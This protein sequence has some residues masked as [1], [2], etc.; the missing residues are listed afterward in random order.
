MSARV[1]LTDVARVTGLAVSTVSMALR[2]DAT[3]ALETQRR[4]QKTADTLGYRPN[5]LLSALASRHFGA[6]QGRDVPIAY[7]PLP[8]MGLT[9]EDEKREIAA[10]KEHSRR[11]GY[12]LE[13]FHPENFQD[14]VEATRIL[15]ARGIQG[16]LLQRSFE[17][18][19]LPG[20]DWSRFSLVGL[21]ERMA[22][23]HSQPPLTTAY[24]A[25]DHF[26]QVVRVWDEIWKRGYRRIGIALFRLSDISLDDQSRWGATQCCLKR[27]PRQSRIP[28]H[29]S[30]GLQGGEESVQQF[31]KWL[32]RYQPDA[33]LGFNG[34]F[35]ALLR[36]Q[37][38]RSPDD[39]GF[40]GLY[41]NLLAEPGHP[42]EISIAGMEEMRSHAILVAL[43]LLDQQIRH[44][45][46]GLSQYPRTLMIHS[47]WIDG[48]TLPDK[49]V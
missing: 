48:E 9:W 31:A 26:G 28:V 30:I 33:I 49:S 11:L 2:N 38:L 21:G 32:H 44:Y 18:K 1:R 36:G 46:S 4:V 10:A 12:H 16:I 35:L 43:D 34:Y 19:M 45:E 13:V 41:R 25:V 23:P 29:L 22:D 5:P 7:I 39:I 6:T 15:F 42:M 27:I 37:G 20:M 14:G 24:A 47:R 3:I 40:A 17:A 8:G